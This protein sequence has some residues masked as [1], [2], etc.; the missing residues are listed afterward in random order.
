V[1]ACAGLGTALVAFSPLGRSLLT[2]TPIPHDVAQGL[3]FLKANPR[4]QAPNHA[5]NIAATDRLRALA[6]EMGEP[7][8]ALA[9]A[10]V[11]SRGD[12][13]L[14]IPGTR[15]VAHFREL[16]RGAELR[17]GPGELEAIEAALPVGW[18]HGD[19]YGEAHWPGVERYC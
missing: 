16:L 3:E 11:L 10:W 18:A 13:V 17:P 6:R 8:A 7:A 9:I 1:Q 12:H 5:A 14:P 19:R 15:S 4:F 2:D